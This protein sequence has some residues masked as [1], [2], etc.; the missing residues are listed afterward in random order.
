VTTLRRSLVYCE[1]RPNLPPTP[2][3]IHRPFCPFGFVALF[4]AAYRVTAIAPNRPPKSVGLGLPDP[5][6]RSRLD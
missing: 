2:D 1:A 6:E 5:S 3:R 4:V